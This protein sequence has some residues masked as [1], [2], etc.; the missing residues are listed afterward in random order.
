MNVC[1]SV[2]KFA[3]SL[4]STEMVIDPAGSVTFSRL[5]SNWAWMLWMSF[6]V[7]SSNRSKASEVTVPAAAG[8][9]NSFMSKM[10]FRV[11]MMVKGG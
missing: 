5:T 2:A 10:S 9:E 8:R 4:L 6:G 3:T 11:D 1:L 7:F